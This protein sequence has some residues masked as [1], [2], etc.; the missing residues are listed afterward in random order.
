MADKQKWWLLSL[1]QV[2]F[3]MQVKIQENF[4]GPNARLR[5]RSYPGSNQPGS[6]VLKVIILTIMVTSKPFSTLFLTSIYSATAIQYISIHQLP[7]I[8]CP[9]LACIVSG[10]IQ[11]SREVKQSFKKKNESRMRCIQVQLRQFLPFIQPFSESQWHRAKQSNPDVTS[12]FFQPKRFPSHMRCIISPACS[13]S[14]QGLL[15]V[16]TSASSRAPELRKTLTTHGASGPANYA[17]APL[18][19]QCLQL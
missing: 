4:N 7:R 18:P 6:I 15:P 1:V 17:L 14:T 19:P 5:D 12:N 2:L 11:L 9:L 3:F 13:G 16:Q 8:S 10:R